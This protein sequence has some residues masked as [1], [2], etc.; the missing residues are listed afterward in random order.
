VVLYDVYSHFGEALL[1][2][3]EHGVWEVLS[4]K[5]TAIT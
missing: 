5:I 2:K 4:M 1:E 3:D